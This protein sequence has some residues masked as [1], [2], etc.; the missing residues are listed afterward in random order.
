MLVGAMRWLRE[1]PEEGVSSLKN[2]A[3][4]IWYIDPREM[5]LTSGAMRYA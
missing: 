1:L 2:Q 5:V 4:R 3:G